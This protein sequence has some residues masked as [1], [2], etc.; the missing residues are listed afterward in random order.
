[1]PY[2]AARHD[3]FPRIFTRRNER[4]AL[5]FGIVFSTAVASAL[6][7]YSYS[8]WS[9]G[10]TVFTYLVTL[11]VV[12]VALPYFISACA[13]LAY[14]VSRRRTV[15]GWLLVRDLMVAGLSILF[16]LWV[17][18]ASGYQAVYQAMV[19][20]LAG[21]PIYAFLKAR[22]EREGTAPEPVDATEEQPLTLTESESE[23]ASV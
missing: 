11:S 13:Q 20:I 9:T 14:L 19:L 5:T 1:M 3:L 18:A 23:L 16:S 22:K 6:M 21:I 15:H 17:T 10:L 4:G 7:A 2:A 12:T 8:G